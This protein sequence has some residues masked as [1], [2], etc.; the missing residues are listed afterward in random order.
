[1]IRSAK[2]VLRFTAAKAMTLDAAGL[3]N[4]RVIISRVPQKNSCPAGGRQLRCRA[5][6]DV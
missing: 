1:V 5:V 4:S 3:Q 6:V 2:T